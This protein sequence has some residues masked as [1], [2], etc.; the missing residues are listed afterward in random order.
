MGLVPAFVLSVN[1]RALLAA[2]AIGVSVSYALVAGAAVGGLNDAQEALAGNLAETS[3]VAAQHDGS[4]FDPGE[5]DPAPDVAI[6][7]TTA[8]EHELYTVRLSDPPVTNASRALAG[9]SSGYASGD[10]IR[11]ADQ[12]LT[13]ERGEP[14]PGA[15][16]ERLGVAPSV[17]EDA[18]GPPAPAAHLGVW[19]DPPEGLAEEL[20][21]AGFE[22]SQAPATFPFYTEGAQQLVSAVQVTVLASAIVVGLLAST[23]VSME[24]RA[25]RSSFA[26]LQ[27]YAGTG[28]V[29]RLV[30]GRG[31]AII[32]AGHAIG[33]GLTLALL[34]ML[35]R[36]G[37][38]ALALPTG[39]LVTA[40]GATVLG[41]LVGLVP[42]VRKAGQRVS[43]MELG[44]D[45]EPW[46]LP[47]PFRLTLTSWRTVI[48]LAVSA[49]I[50]AGSLGVIFGAVDMPNQI[51]GVD[52]A[53]VI[54]ET[55]NNPLRGT[56]P[57]FLGQHLGS[58]DGYK[59]SSPE[60]YA[61]TAIDGR[62]VMVRGV[63][64]ASLTT[65]EPVRLVAGEPPDDSGEVVLGE[66]LA[67]QLDAEVG[68][69]LF[70][71]ASYS[72]HAVHL[73]VVG[74]ASAPGLL[75]DEAL[76][77][78]PTARSL[79]GVGPD[80]VNIVRYRVDDPPDPNATRRPA[81]PS[82]IEA[83]DLSVDPSDPIPL[84]EATAVVDLVN[85]GDS[86]S[87][88][89]L[90][91]FVNN[92]P[93]SDAWATV[94]PH[95][96]GQAELPFRVPRTG[97]VTL[98]VNPSEQLEPSD[99]AYEIDAPRA[100]TNGTEVTVTVTRTSDDA[101]AEGVQVSLGDE[102]AT[103]GSEGQATLEATGIGNRTLLADGSEG[104]G[105]ASLLVV[106]PGDLYRSHLI[107]P[108]ISG[109]TDI[110]PGTWSGAARVENI[111]GE[112]FDGMA[113]IPVDGEARNTTELRL[114][115]GQSTR[116]T[117][118]LE[119]DQGRHRVGTGPGALTVSVGD[120]DEPA[121]GDG[122]GSDGNG[123]DGDGGSDPGTGDGGSDG[124]GGGGSPGDG[125]GDPDG[126][127]PPAGDE[128]RIVELLRQR[129]ERGAGGEGAAQEDLDPLQAFLGDTF[130]NF[131]AAVTIVTIATVLHAG[132]IGLVAVRRDVEERAA[133]LG[134]LSSIGADGGNQRWH[135]VREFATVG[136]VATIVGT[137]AGLGLVAL[138]A[139]QAL[140]GGFGHALVPRTSWGFALRVAA[141]SLGVTL[142]ATVLAVEQVRQ[143]RVSGL[144]SEGP[145]R[146]ERPPLST[147]IGGDA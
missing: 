86:T 89:H 142:L 135:A 54:A 29:Q 121:T 17:F 91:L 141:V 21:Q 55:D 44:E 74:I 3:L 41:G 107:F 82:G 23:V 49:A 75:G 19:S 110:D 8:G 65:M 80:Q 43:A 134:T 42:P 50:L 115:S 20:E 124:D 103:T 67:G 12:N 96:T 143:R 28:L 72:P 52:D 47:R 85:F 145:A 60:I 116:I 111:G 88:R 18:G 140:V 122:D 100:V 118:S 5:L 7:H 90:T 40:M 11:I 113:T 26:T 139:E 32:A 13:V 39:Y 109:P 68:Q 117:F 10:V 92:E 108:H 27:V 46:H 105:V 133:T 64:W 119:L 53:R 123:T 61:P 35:E 126:E 127:P 81:L 129:A 58:V 147:L 62:P 1:R 30:A 106:E 33:G 101:P 84:Q 4:S 120:V 22:V 78:L 37:A 56:A 99:P 70:V 73:E 112:A 146:S 9:P 25:K 95:E 128:P 31:V 36:A 69:R 6:A 87:T 79:T 48:P 98:N 144:L 63:H 94:G 125:G 24:L 83:T 131:N 34:F 77:D 102:L 132:L 93:V 137:L 71:A 97:L 57:A 66:R 15:G 51:F 104:R 76:V 138:A 2:L 136:L 59:G 130:E 16:P 38:A 14:S 45:D 114:L